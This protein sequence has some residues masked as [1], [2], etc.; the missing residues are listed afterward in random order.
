MKQEKAAEEL[1]DYENIDSPVE[2]L[3]DND[4]L[5]EALLDAPQSVLDDMISQRRCNMF[6]PLW[7]QGV[8]PKHDVVEKVKNLEERAIEVWRK[9]NPE[10]ELPDW[11]IRMEAQHIVLKGMVDMID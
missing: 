1:K 7:K 9:E 5:F 3:L 2:M 8:M 6:D 10:Y 11:V 4:E